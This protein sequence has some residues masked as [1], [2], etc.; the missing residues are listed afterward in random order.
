MHLLIAIYT[1]TILI[2]IYIF[3]TYIDID[4]C[5]HNI[6]TNTLTLIHLQAARARGG[7]PG[8]SRQSPTSFLRPGITGAEPL[9]VHGGESGAAETFVAHPG[10]AWHGKDRNLCHLGVSPRQTGHGAGACFV[11]YFFAFCLFLS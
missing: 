11:V 7:A 3:R 5:T 4:I 2:A 10:P 9:S 1:Y 6:L 8:P